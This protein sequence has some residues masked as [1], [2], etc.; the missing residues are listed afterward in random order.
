MKLETIPIQTL[1]TKG[2]GGG[3]RIIYVTG[4]KPKPA[5]ELHRPALL[6]V[7]GASLARISP[8]AEVWLR[9]R[10]EHFALVT[11]TPELYS[12]P[13]DLAPD[14]PGIER[15]LDAPVASEQD[16]REANSLAR[17]VFRCWH[18]IGDSYPVLTRIMASAQLRATLADVRRYLTNQAGVADRIRGHLKSAL[19]EAWDAGAR[20]LVIGHSL[21]SVVV[22]DSLWQLAREE[23]AAGRCELLITL[24]S[25]LAT[26]FIRKGLMGADRDGAD[27]Y[28]DNIDHWMNVAARGEMVALHRRIRPFFE[29]MLKLGLLTSLEDITDIYNHFRSED[30]LN[31]HKSYGYLNHPIVA[32][33]ITDWLGYSSSGSILTSMRR[34]RSRP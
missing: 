29:S 16:R 9:Q 6:R 10:P 12:E 28:P 17:S 31:V 26:R 1:E 30:G 23:R 22:Y 20:V 7:L 25:P 2:Q 8:D 21:G 18:L 15:L 32:G 27:R 11:W 33:A 19:L 3:Q 5:P 14:L 34:F 24:G 4:M 13:G